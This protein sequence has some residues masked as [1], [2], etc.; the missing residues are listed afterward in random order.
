M[1]GSSSISRRPGMSL[2]AVGPLSVDYPTQQF[3]GAHEEGGRSDVRSRWSARAVAVQLV[4]NGAA[5]AI[6]GALAGVALAGALLVPT[7]P[8]WPALLALTGLAALLAG[9]LRRGREL[10]RPLEDLEGLIARHVPGPSN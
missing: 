1:S 5:L 8:V 7:A 9:L 3:A 2:S 4:W 10:A 6:V